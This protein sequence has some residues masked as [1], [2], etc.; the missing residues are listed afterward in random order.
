M[1]IG[2]NAD[3]RVI[4]T[5]DFFQKTLASVDFS[6]RAAHRATG[7]LTAILV[8]ALTSLIFSS[9]DHA[10]RIWSNALFVTD[11]GH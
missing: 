4:F 2:N 11:G 7:V 10:A 9:T 1:A 6:I 8:N 5:S 3:I